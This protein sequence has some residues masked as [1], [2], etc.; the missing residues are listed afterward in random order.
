VAKLASFVR[1]LDDP[2]LDE[3]REVAAAHGL[4]VNINTTAK[5]LGRPAIE[6]YS[7]R[8]GNPLLGTFR[9]AA[10]ALEWLQAGRQEASHAPS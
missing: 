3:L 5:V 2:D 7:K 10:Q 1:P 4:A 6:I 8:P 9:H